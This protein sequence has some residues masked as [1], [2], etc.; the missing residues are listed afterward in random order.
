MKYYS[1]PFMKCYRVIGRELV[2]SKTLIPDCP[3]GYEL[4]RV[5][6]VGI[7]RADLLQVAGLYPP[8][9]YAAIPG[10][11]VA[12]E[13]EYGTRVAAL[14]H[15]GGYAEYVAVDK[16]MLFPIPDEM[17]FT[18]AA[19]L[20][21]ALVTC[22]LNLIVLGCLKKG[23]RALVHAGTSGIGTMAIQLCNSLGIDVFTTTSKPHYSDKLLSLGAKE[24]LSYDNYD[25][26]IREL[27]E[28]DVV[29]DILSGKHTDKKPKMF[30][31]IW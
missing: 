24:V 31:K 7:N 16:G 28:V 1:M 20:P 5:H 25:M 13:T 10:L 27:G 21:E 4:I 14:M 3:D 30:K 2:Y 6:S 19:A 12:G 15:S 11:E 8:P 22:Y 23:M 26:K 18:E 29:L 9:D 17:S